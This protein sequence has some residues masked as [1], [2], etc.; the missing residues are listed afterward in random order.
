MY[1][2]LKSRNK[3]VFTLFNPL[4]PK[5]RYT[6]S[7]NMV[8]KTRKAGIPNVQAIEGIQGYRVI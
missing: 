4:N 3:F 8:T 6:G 5:G 2:R 7:T 1:F